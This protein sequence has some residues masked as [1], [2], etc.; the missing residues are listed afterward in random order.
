MG[1]ELRF[2]RLSWWDGVE[3]VELSGPPHILWEENSEV[4]GR[5]VF[6]MIQSHKA[7]LAL[8]FPDPYKVGVVS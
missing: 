1:G 3:D 8:R 4:E 5:K 2:G 7:T 6:S